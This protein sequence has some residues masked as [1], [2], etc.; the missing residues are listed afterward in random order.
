MNF[1][2]SAPEPVKFSNCV[3]VN[4]VALTTFVPFAKMSAVVPF[5]LIAIFVVLV[6]VKYNDV[7]VPPTAFLIV[8]KLVAGEPAPK[9]NVNLSV[10]A[11]LVNCKPS[12]K[13]SLVYAIFPLNSTN[14][15]PPLAEIKPLVYILFRL[16]ESATRVAVAD[17]VGM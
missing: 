8:T 7:N 6:V 14:Q 3:A 13:A 10:T 17:V 12:A 11:V 5:H 15:V 2:V 1:G 9:V 16:K 4:D